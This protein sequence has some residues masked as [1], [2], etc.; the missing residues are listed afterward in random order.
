MGCVVNG[1]G[2]A[3]DANIGV[4]CGAGSGAVFVSG[5]IVRKVSED[6][7]VDALP[8]KRK[9]YRTQRNEIQR[10]DLRC[11]ENA[12]LAIFQTDGGTEK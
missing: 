9:D 12:I 1:P 7:I 4:A 6:A 5:K 10:F 8:C 11:Q 2:E 3:A